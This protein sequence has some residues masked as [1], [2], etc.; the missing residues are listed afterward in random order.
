MS[1]RFVLL[2]FFSAQIFG[3][4]P[5]KSSHSFSLPLGS[6]TVS[7]L[8]QYSNGHPMCKEDVLPKLSFPCLLEPSN[9]TREHSPCVLQVLL[10]FIK[11][12]L[13][14]MHVYVC[15]AIECETVCSQSCVSGWR[16]LVLPMG[17]HDR[18]DATY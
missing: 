15:F 12:P 18:V 11:H 2:L 16:L 4:A 3:W 17:G 5:H 10:L 7:K 14:Y 6:S 13:I 8:K 9:H 1:P